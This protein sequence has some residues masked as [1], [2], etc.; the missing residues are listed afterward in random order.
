MS[1]TDDLPR[2]AIEARMARGLKRALSPLSDQ[3]G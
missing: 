1:Y 3:T 2:T